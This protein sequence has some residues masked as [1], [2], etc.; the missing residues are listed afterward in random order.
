MAESTATESQ[1][2]P[3]P[4]ANSSALPGA[5]VVAGTFDYVQLTQTTVP[6]RDAQLAFGTPDAAGRLPIILLPTAPFRIR[7]HGGP[8]RCHFPDRRRDPRRDGRGQWPWPWPSASSWWSIGI[9][10]AFFVRIPEGVERD[11]PAARPI[12]EDAGPRQPAAHAVDRRLAPGHEPGRSRSTSPRRRLPTPR[13]F[14][15][16]G[17]YS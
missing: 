10:P 3:A 16:G 13:V 12:P 7:H 5:A 11:P 8:H 15:R 4:P 2:T 1:P 9:V 6:L 14:G 17:L